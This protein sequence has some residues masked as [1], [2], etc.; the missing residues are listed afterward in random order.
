MIRN[1][2]KKPNTFLAG[3]SK[4]GTTSLASYL[5]T[6][7]DIYVS[8]PKEPDWFL[9]GSKKS[10]FNS[11]NEY[12]RSCFT[13]EDYKITIDANVACMFFENPILRILD[14]NPDAKFVIMVRNPVDAARSLF[15][16][17]KSRFEENAD[18][19]KEAWKLQS[20]RA[21]GE[22]LPPNPPTHKKMLQYGEIYKFGK[23]IEWL[24]S[25]VDPNRVYVIKLSDLKKEPEKTYKKTLD[26]LDVQRVVNTDFPKKNKA[27]K[28]RFQFIYKLIRQATSIKQ[29]IG[30]PYLNTGFFS[31]LHNLNSKKHERGALNES[32]RRE[33]EE[34]FKEDAEKLE[35]L[36]GIDVLS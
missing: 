20:K 3:F 17:F 5:D 19:F 2:I 36:T 33:L 23:R 21:N 18:F 1:N 15:L 27:S 32:F 16:H 26:F 22:S 14:F 10:R 13:D 4:C 28:K 8:K 9:L 12:L 6:H 35:K 25:E 31:K 24:F 29:K 7:P 34:H 30:I 11:E